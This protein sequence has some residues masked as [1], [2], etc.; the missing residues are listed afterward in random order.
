V[1]FDDVCLKSE[2]GNRSQGN[3]NEDLTGE[4][5]RE[6]QIPVSNGKKA[7]EGSKY[8]NILKSK[9]PSEGSEVEAEL[10]H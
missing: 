1:F 2:Y 4:T 5:G 6:L 3:W 9:S 8:A 10:L 7:A